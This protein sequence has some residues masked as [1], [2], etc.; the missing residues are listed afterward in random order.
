MMQL[1]PPPDFCKYS[2][3]FKSTTSAIS[4]FMEILKFCSLGVRGW[5]L[6]GEERKKKDI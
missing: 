5:S 1:P 4:L 2:K 6:Q 3:N